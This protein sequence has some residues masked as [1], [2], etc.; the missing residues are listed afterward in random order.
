[1]FNNE[2]IVLKPMSSKEM[3][4]KQEVKPKDDPKQQAYASDQHATRSRE[5][6]EQIEEPNQQTEMY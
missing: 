3:K 6:K 1:M 2:T 5:P 4:R